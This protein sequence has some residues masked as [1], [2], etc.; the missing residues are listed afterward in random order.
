MTTTTKT[1]AQ[2]S[3]MS[4]PAFR[5]DREVCNTCERQHSSTWFRDTEYGTIVC[6]VCWPGHQ[7]RF[8]TTVVQIPAV[9]SRPALEALAS[10]LPRAEAALLVAFVA[11]YDG[12]VDAQMP[13]RTAENAAA[14]ARLVAAF[15]L[16]HDDGPWTHVGATPAGRA[17]LAR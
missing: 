4:T 2:A 6:R 13:P 10:G 12:V 1:P 11:L 7:E 16:V 14:L 8:G 3:R 9:K 17:V 5:G 15:L